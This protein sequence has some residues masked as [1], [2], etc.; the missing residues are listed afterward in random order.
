MLA[1]SN[2]LNE[3]SGVQKSK[4]LSFSGFITGLI[5]KPSVPAP[6]IPV[7]TTKPHSQSKIHSL[8][9]RI[10]ESESNTRRLSLPFFEMIK[11]NNSA[12]LS[13]IETRKYKEKVSSSS[14]FSSLTPSLSSSSSFS[15]L[16]STD[17]G[18]SMSAKQ[19]LIPHS[20]SNNTHH[21]NQHQQHQHQHHPHSSKD[22]A[23]S[24]METDK[25]I[26]ELITV[27]KQATCHFTLP[28]ELSAGPAGQIISLLE[29]FEAIHTTGKTE[30]GDANSDS[31]FAG[32]GSG[33]VK[34]KLRQTVRK[35]TSKFHTLE[36]NLISVSDEQYADACVPDPSPSL[37]LATTPVSANIPVP[38]AKEEETEYMGPFTESLPTD[39]VVSTVELMRFLSTNLILYPA[40][41]ICISDLLL[42]QQNFEYTTES[43][44][45]LQ[46]Q[47]IEVVNSFRKLLVRKFDTFASWNYIMNH[48]IGNSKFATFCQSIKR[49]SIIHEH[50]NRKFVDAYKVALIKW[51]KTAGFPDKRATCATYIDGCAFASFTGSNDMINRKVTVL[52][53][54]SDDQ[55]KLNEIAAHQSFAASSGGINYDDFDEVYSNFSFDVGDDSGSV[56]VVDIVDDED[57]DL[58]VFHTVNVFKQTETATFDNHSH[59]NNIHEYPSSARFLKPALTTHD[60]T[61]IRMVHQP[62]NHSKVQSF[63]SEP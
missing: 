1:T 23:S 28:D 53:I 10:T 3:L 39:V 40:D 20:E 47:I 46:Q 43:S 4:R 22:I 6:S 34:D 49:T 57:A 42:S 51:N 50:D 14:T 11:K 17:Y 38:A 21:L 30:T 35:V 24:K 61:S 5:N 59:S 25:D 26:Q 8:D 62:M 54:T 29:T 12:A 48:S 58:S 19:P 45:L 33:Y 2:N 13:A 41:M 31:D 44:L 52:R 32:S 37:V 27:L 16:S 55:H 18:S 56:D 60:V 7:K 9:K 36:T 15:S 63:L